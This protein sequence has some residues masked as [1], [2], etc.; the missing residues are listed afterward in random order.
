V[1]INIA[2]IGFGYW[3]PNLVR[4]L[5]KISDCSVS[6]IVD[7]DKEK[8]IRAR[9]LYPDTQC[10]KNI[11]EVLKNKSINACVISLPVSC[12]YKYAKLVL[13]NNKHLL[14]EKPA[15]NSLKKLNNLVSIAKSRNLSLMVDYTFLY[16][17]A[18]KKIKEII[19]SGYIGEIL[20]VNAQRYNSIYRKDVNII[21]DLAVHDISIFQYLLQDMP[22]SVN[23]QGFSSITEN[24]EDFTDITLK[25]SKTV[26]HISASWL[27]PFKTK[28]MVICGSKK[29]IVY[30]D[31]ESIN[32]VKVYNSVYDI[33]KKT[34]TL[35]Y[36]NEKVLI[37]KLNKQEALYNMCKDFISSVKNKT[38]PLSNINFALQISAILD[39]CSKSIL[40]N[41]KEIKL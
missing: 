29:T 28:K 13:E 33:L 21:R 3:G 6:Y 10:T 36:D 4:N 32:K 22:K 41:G 20:F 7:S 11:D 8:L 17:G 34:K 5:S 12:H 16:T 23:V 25:Y 27:F 24:I 39:A 15:T 31:M 35:N 37:P 30:D 26:S 18:V 38:V 14:I 40:R 2:V 19:D 1:K 9:K